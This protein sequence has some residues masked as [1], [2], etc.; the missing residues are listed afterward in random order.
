[1]DVNHHAVLVDVGHFQMQPFLEYEA[2]GINGCQKCSIVE[3]SDPTEYTVNF[4]PTE[5]AWKTLFLLGLQDLE[6]MPLSLDD[7][8]IKKP[9]AGVTDFHGV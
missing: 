8:L 4:F 5:D 7:V 3:C 1:M 2:A 9:D 6:D